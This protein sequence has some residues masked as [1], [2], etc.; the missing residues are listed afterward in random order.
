MKYL[1]KPF[2]VCVDG[3]LVKG[4]KILFLKRNVEPFKGYWHVVGGHVEETET[5][6]QALEREFKEETDL[7]VEVKEIIDARIEETFDRIK[8]IIAYRVISAKGKIKLNSENCE[9]H[10]FSKIPSQSVY[11]Y[12]KV[13]QRSEMVSKK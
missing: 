9:Y 13:F 2:C 4:G 1:V 11:D 6:K 7:D 12:S 8:I 10:W 5:P 3:I